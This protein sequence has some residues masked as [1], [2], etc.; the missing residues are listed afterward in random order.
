MRAMIPIILRAAACESRSGLIYIKGVGV[1]AARRL[2][3][4]GQAG[5]AS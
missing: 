4:R 5:G 2:L 3:S 1:A